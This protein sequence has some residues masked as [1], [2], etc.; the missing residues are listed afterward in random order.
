MG[1]SKRLCKHR[2]A[3]FD[4]GCKKIA[5]RHSSD[6]FDLL[7]LL[8]R[9]KYREH[10]PAFSR[11]HSAAET[12]AAL[13]LAQDIRTDPKSQPCPHVPLGGE[14]WLKELLPD[15]WSDPGP[16]VANRQPHARSLV[17]PV[18]VR[19]RQANQDAPPIA[20]RINAVVQQVGKKLT[21][22]ARDPH[23]RRV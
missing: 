16:V 18:L 7:R 9:K 22:L 10:G 4:Y 19:G 12:N 17:P 5:A 13:V 23:Q 21:N 11:G 3:P 8:H 15:L 14:E 6:C 20:H 2:A 1:L